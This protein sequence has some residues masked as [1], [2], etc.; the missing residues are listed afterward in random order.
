LIRKNFEQ[1]WVGVTREALGF[2]GRDSRRN[3]EEVPCLREGNHVILQHLTI[4]RL[5]AEGHLRLLIDKQKLGIVRGE[6]F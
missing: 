5:N 3:A 1:L 2:D 4:D 6:N